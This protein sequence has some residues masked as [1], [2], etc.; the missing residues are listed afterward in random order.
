MSY[1]FAIFAAMSFVAGLVCVNGLLDSLGE[2]I[3]SYASLFLLAVANFAFVL[4]NLASM[5]KHI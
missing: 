2:S 4:L 1:F 5:Y 3:G